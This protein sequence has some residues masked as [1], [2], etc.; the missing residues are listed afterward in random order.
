MGKKSPRFYEIKKA[1]WYLNHIWAGLIMAEPNQDGVLECI[2]KDKNWTAYVWLD[3]GVYENVSDGG[4]SLIAQY[5]T[6]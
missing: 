1:Q 5:L 6:N 4:K 2:G 3:D